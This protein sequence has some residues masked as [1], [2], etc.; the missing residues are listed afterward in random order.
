MQHSTRFADLPPIDPVTLHQRRE[1]VFILLAG[2]FLGTLAM[3][4]LLGVSRFIRLFEVPFGT[5]PAGDTY[6]LAFTVAVGVL[7]YPVTFF[8]TDLISEF[9]GRRRANF[10]VFVGL[11]LNLWLIAILW[12]GA[13]LPG[14]EPPGEEPAFFLIRNLAM[15][16]VGASMVAYMAA[17]FCDVFVF[18]FWK[19]L[20]RG[21]WLW[22]RNCGSTFV[23]QLI[24]SFA[25]ILLTWHFTEALDGVVAEMPDFPLAVNLGALIAASYFFKLAVA[26]VDTGPIYIA[27]HFLSRYLR[28]DPWTEG[29]GDSERVRLAFPVKDESVPR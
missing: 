28:I 26:A 13:V 19:R 10:V 5:D 4:N 1:R 18:H 14:A 22:L 15:A 9:Y 23:S 27:V 20:T 25:V 12:L 2:I 8:C 21:R 11:I 3:L 24:D 7:P 16:A 6:Y 29:G 17:Q